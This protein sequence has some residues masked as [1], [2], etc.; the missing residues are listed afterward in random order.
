[1]IAHTV[2]LIGLITDFEQWDR[3]RKLLFLLS[4]LYF[5]NILNVLIL[6]LSFIFL[7]N[8]FLL[9]TE[10]QRYIREQIEKP[11]LPVF[12]CRLDQVQSGLF[13]LIITG[14]FSSDLHM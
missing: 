3:S 10:D 7:A 4:R 11:Y 12:T 13:Q 5:A 8:P 6:G 14:T 2:S 1:V 9:A